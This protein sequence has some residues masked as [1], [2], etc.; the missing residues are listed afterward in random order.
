MNRRKALKLFGLGV[1]VG[2]VGSATII[3]ESEAKPM[4]E[5]PNPPFKG[6]THWYYDPAP[7][8]EIDVK[9][10]KTTAWSRPDGA[11][12]LHIGSEWNTSA[13]DGSVT[14]R[15]NSKEAMR[16][17]AGGLWYYRKGDWMVTYDK[18]KDT[19]SYRKWQKEN[20]LL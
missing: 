3:N 8:G 12:T 5:E 17:T 15:S 19:D 11:Q 9:L 4:I 6:A 13:D 18:V 7:A 1:C 10:E 16:L 14:F 20:G 2:A